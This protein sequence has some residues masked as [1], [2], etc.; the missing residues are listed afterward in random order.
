MAGSCSSSV[1]YITIHLW[2]FTAGSFSLSESSESA[3]QT[4]GFL[5]L[6]WVVLLLALVHH[7]SL[8][9]NTGVLD[10]FLGCLSIGLSNT[11]FSFCE[12]SPG[13]SSVLPYH[14]MQTA[15]EDLL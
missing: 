2:S 8:S 9:T 15:F 14:C 3:S 13:F 11:V 4:Q 7:L 1:L 6:F 10:A 5:V 12:T